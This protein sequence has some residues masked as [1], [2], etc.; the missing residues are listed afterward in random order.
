MGTRL[1]LQ[2]IL[3]KVLGSRNVYFQPG[4]SIMLKYPC[5]VYARDSNYSEHANNKLYLNRQRYLVT[6][7]DKNPDSAFVEKLKRLE[8]SEYSRYYSSDNLHHD[9]FTIYY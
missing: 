7:I 3:E 5:I 1:E 6:L 4:P 8:Y 9:V 2:E